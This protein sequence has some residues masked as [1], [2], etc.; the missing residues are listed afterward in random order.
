MKK[1]DELSNIF[2]IICLFVELVCSFILVC[3]FRAQQF[4]YFFG[5][6]Q[7]RQKKQ[8]IEKIKPLSTILFTIHSI[9]RTIT[10]LFSY[11]SY[12]LRSNNY[13]NQQTKPI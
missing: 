9:N 11:I 2:D 6:S 8:K 10:Q 4:L 1:K 5:V 12:Y 7:G 3:F 13:Q